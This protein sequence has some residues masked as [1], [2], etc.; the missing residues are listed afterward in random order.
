GRDAM[1]LCHKYQFV[2]NLHLAVEAAFLGEIA[3]SL[4][5]LTAKRFSKETKLSGVRQ[6]DADHH[7]NCA[8]LA[9]PIRT[10]QAVDAPGVD[11]QGEIIDG[12]L[13]PIGLPYFYEF[14]C[15]HG[16]CH[17]RVYKRWRRNN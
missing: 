7:A 1:Q 2:E 9:S 4:E 6:S 13:L 12:D 8:G 3:D 11:G 17:L 14:Y 10:E 15:L 5:V 16:I